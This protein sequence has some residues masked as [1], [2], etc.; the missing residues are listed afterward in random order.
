MSSCREPGCKNPLAGV[1]AT[2]HFNVYHRRAIFVSNIWLA[3]SIQDGL[4]HCVREGCANADA[5]AEKA[6]H[7]HDV[8]GISLDSSE[9]GGERGAS[10]GV[11]LD[12]RRVKDE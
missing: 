8:C 1:S 7:H 4:F 5:D 2:Q 3:R 6:K 11:A 9:V 12:L 10:V